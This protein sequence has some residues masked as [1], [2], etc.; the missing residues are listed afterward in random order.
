MQ[1]AKAKKQSQFLTSLT[2]INAGSL[3][4]AVLPITH[5]SAFPPG[6]PVHAFLNIHS[7]WDDSTACA[8]ELTR[9]MESMGAPIEIH[10]VQKGMDIASAV[11]ESVADGATAIV[12]G[13]GDGT[14]NAVASALRGTSVPMA[15]LP[16]G[17]LNHLARDLG[18]P[19]KADEAIHALSHSR[20]LPMD[21]GEVNGRI[22]LNNSIIGLYPAYAFLRARYEEQ[23]R[24]KWLA[25]LSAI[26]SVFRRNPS[27]TVR[28]LVD[29]QS[30]TRR[31]PYIL[32]ANN[33]HRMEGY[34]LGERARLDQGRLWVYAMRR[35]SRWGWCGLRS[36]CF[37]AG[38]TS[39]TI[40][41]RS[42]PPRSRFRPAGSV[43]GWL[44][45]E[46]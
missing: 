41:K 39:A 40:S 44:W 37:S 1:A 19:L 8:D 26:I 38:S 28:L 31:T 2:Y 4:P 36:H 35:L 46:M 24:A 14:L 25:V 3:A 17:T 43:W 16:I 23:G 33:E 11:R 10:Q 32:I 7:G 13:G 27:F 21:L 34:Q 5:M 9:E 42:T 30:I 15:I 18:V 29:G 12:A 20:T 22:F 45:M 6:R